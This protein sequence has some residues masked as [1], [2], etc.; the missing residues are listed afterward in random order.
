MAEKVWLALCEEVR[1]RDVSIEWAVPVRI[2]VLERLAAAGFWKGAD[3]RGVLP[4][5]DP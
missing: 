5:F 1:R 2:G 4:S 3:V